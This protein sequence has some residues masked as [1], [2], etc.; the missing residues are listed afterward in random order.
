MKLINWGKIILIYFCIGILLCSCSM[1][2]TQENLYATPED[3]IKQLEIGLNEHDIEKLIECTDNNLQ[4]VLSG[5]AK[6]L[7]SLTGLDFESLVELT[8]GISGMSE[9]DLNKV[10][11]ALTI[12]NVIYTDEKNC[13]VEVNAVASLDEQQE[14]ELLQI[15][16]TLQ[17]EQWKIKIT[18][19]DLGIDIFS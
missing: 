8:T 12:N 9:H 3:A 18:L 17:K 5:G 19:S 7:S 2:E 10:K 14:Q 6:L 1:G 4:K 13:L 11:F 16:L 15:P